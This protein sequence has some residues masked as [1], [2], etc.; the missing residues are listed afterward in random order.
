LFWETTVLSVVERVERLPTSLQNDIATRVGKYIYFAQTAT[1]DATMLRFIEAA[2]EERAK[3][4][5]KS[6]VDPRWSAP[7]L[8]EAWCVSRLGLSNGNMNRLSALL[9][10]TAVEAFVSKGGT[11]ST[12]SPKTTMQ[13]NDSP[14]TPCDRFAYGRIARLKTTSPFPICSL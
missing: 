12:H 9:V 7:A 13:S 10:I 2:A 5:Q 3:V 14:A 6:T 1:D 11:A 8:A 4:V